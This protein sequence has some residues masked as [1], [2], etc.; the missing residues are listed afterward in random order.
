MPVGEKLLPGLADRTS[1]VC[2]F[3]DHTVI[4]LDVQS[5]TDPNPRELLSVRQPG[6]QNARAHPCGYA[7]ISLSSAIGSEVRGE[8]RFDGPRNRE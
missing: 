8:F 3:N 7:C 5:A 2:R 1:L 6:Y 4:I